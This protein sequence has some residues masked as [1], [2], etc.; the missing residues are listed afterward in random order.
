MILEYTEWAPPELRRFVCQEEQVVWALEHA[1]ATDF[2]A[3]AQVLLGN[4]DRTALSFKQQTP[5]VERIVKRLVESTQPM[6]RALGVFALGRRTGEGRSEALDKALKDEDPWVRLAAVRGAYRM[7]ETQEAREARL[8]PLV[9]DS[10]AVVATA[11][12]RALL[13]D[14]VYAAANL[15][16]A[17][18]AFEYDEIHV[19]SYVTSSGY[20]GDAAA[21]V[22]LI[23]RKPAFL[24][25]ARRRLTEP[26]DAEDTE[27]PSTMT[28]LLAQYG[29][30]SGLEKMLGEWEAAKS[31]DPPTE[32]LIGLTLSKDR[33][34]LPPVRKIVAGAEHASELRR[35]LTYLRGMTGEEARV[36][37]QEINE[38][39]R[40][41]N[42]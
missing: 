10:I 32:L 33:R 6:A 29:D 20:S 25:A 36:L 5:E 2:T 38:R 16:G 9:A 3:I 37:R 21:P 15:R 8:G 26:H 30:F 19:W 28:L 4:A 34:F 35:V 24:E 41:L 1:K 23:D 40:N 18:S 39:M 13:D 27:T 17:S 22:M 31:D 7:A 11:A 12:A 14:T 42:D